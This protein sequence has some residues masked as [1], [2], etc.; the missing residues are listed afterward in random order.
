MSIGFEMRLPWPV[1]GD[2]AF[3]GIGDI[4]NRVLV[5][6]FDFPQATWLK[7][8]FFELTQDEVY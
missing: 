5:N 4:S 7:V 1:S 3:L 2:V 6:H 8:T